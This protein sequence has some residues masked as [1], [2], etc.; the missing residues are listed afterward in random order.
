MKIKYL[1]IASTCCVALTVA[2]NA[3]SLRDKQE[4]ATQEGYMKSSIEHVTKNCGQE[5]PL[6]WDWSSFKVAD[7]KEYGPASFCGEALSAVAELCSKPDG[8]EAVLK[9]IKSIECKASTPRSITLKDG[10]LSYG[11]EWTAPNNLDAIRAYLL[12]AL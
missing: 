1:F 2:A 10:V 5:I 6:K 9:S 3:Q 11:I 4:F 12:D 8:K 7:F